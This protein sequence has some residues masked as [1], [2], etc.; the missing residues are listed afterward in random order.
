MWI[1]QQCADI[2]WHSDWYWTVRSGYL[3]VYWLNWNYS[4]T[5]N[6]IVDFWSRKPRGRWWNSNDWKPDYFRTFYM[7]CDHND[8][9]SEGP[10]LLSA[11]NTQERLHKSNS[12]LKLRMCVYGWWLV[13]MSFSISFVVYWTGVFASIYCK[14]PTQIIKWRKQIIGAVGNVVS[15]VP[16]SQTNSNT[17]WNQLRIELG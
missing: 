1:I 14:I 13:H 3:C 10:S 7:W 6:G 8:T 12:L 16:I 9:N 2:L 5:H 4:G 11:G 15:R 17:N